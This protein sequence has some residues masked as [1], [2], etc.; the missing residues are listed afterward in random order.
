MRQLFMG[1]S[2]RVVLA[3]ASSLVRRPEGSEELCKAA[4]GGGLHGSQDRPGRVC[5]CPRAPVLT[6]S[7]LPHEVA[8]VVGVAELKTSARCLC[9]SDLARASGGHASGLTIQR[10]HCERALRPK[11]TTGVVR[12]RT[13]DRTAC[14]TNQPISP[15]ANSPAPGCGNSCLRCPS[16]SSA[17]LTTA[18][19]VLSWDTR[20]RAN[21]YA[22]STPRG[23][24]DGGGL[25]E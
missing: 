16:N 9:G 1:R 4:P 10:T 6:E 8:T 19:R 2:E 5:R 17:V 12:R 11:L 25:S 22:A 18:G 23:R 13:A 15:A 7:P 14:S 3:D 20:Q 21:S 24:P